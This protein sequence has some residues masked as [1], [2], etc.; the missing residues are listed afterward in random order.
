[1]LTFVYLTTF[2][3]TQEAANF[4]RDVA[5]APVV[6]VPP[7]QSNLHSDE[8]GWS[9]FPA[10]LS[11]IRGIAMAFAESEER[12]HA[13][14]MDVVSQGDRELCHMLA[15][16]LF[17]RDRLTAEFRAII[18]ARGISTHFRPLTASENAALALGDPASQRAPDKAPRES[19]PAPVPQERN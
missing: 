11:A 4:L 18:E 1:M 17:M 8:P 19:A 14:V 7:E 12:M 3:R 9:D 16:E 13:A 10:Q 5:V 6:R 2:I 15:L